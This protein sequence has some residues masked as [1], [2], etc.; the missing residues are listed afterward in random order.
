MDDPVDGVS[1]DSVA[2]GDIAPG[3]STTFTLETDAETLAPD[4]TV[5]A[6]WVSVQTRETAVHTFI[7]VHTA[8]E[9]EPLEVVWGIPL[10]LPSN[11]RLFQEPSAGLSL[12]HI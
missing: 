7:G 1:A 12:I 9:Y 5:G 6:A 2:L 4:T 3:D 10:L 11:P 8:K